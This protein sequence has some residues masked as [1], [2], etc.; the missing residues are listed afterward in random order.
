MTNVTTKTLTASSS[1]QRL[2]HKL[3]TTSV[4]RRTWIWNLTQPLLFCISVVCFCRKAGIWVISSSNLF[5]CWEGSWKWQEEED[6]KEKEKKW[7]FSA[8]CWKLGSSDFLVVVA[9]YS[10]VANFLQ[11]F[12]LELWFVAIVELFCSVLTWSTQYALAK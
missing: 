5:V 10:K 12:F 3:Q 11:I 1:M 4:R 8:F 2:A 9:K 7:S 6:Q